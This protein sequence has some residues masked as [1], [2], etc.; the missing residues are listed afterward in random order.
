MAIV[1]T[2]IGVGTAAGA[3]LVTFL[4]ANGAM[5]LG[6]SLATVAAAGAVAIAIRSQAAGPAPAEGAEASIEAPS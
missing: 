1:Q 2:S 6:G 5:I 4:G 3:P